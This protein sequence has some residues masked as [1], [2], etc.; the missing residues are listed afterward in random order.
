MVFHKKS[1]TRGRA[2][3]QIAAKAIDPGSTCR[4]R[5]AGEVLAQTRFC[6]NEFVDQVVIN[7]AAKRAMTK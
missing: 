4:T 3:G 1:A 6:V 5:F 2:K 7:T